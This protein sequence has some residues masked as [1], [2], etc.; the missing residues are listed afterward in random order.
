MAIFSFFVILI[1]FLLIDGVWLSIMVSRFYTP[2]IGHLMSESLSL[3]PAAIFYVLYGFALNILIVQ[4]ALKNNTG[5]GEL[6]LMGLL[7]GMVTYGTYDLTNQATIK[8]WPWI[9]TVVDIAWGSFLAA[10]VTL[11]STALTRLFW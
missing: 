9:V 10:S 2:N 11:I 5:Y 4:P 7:F 8:G 6:L 3:L 1:S